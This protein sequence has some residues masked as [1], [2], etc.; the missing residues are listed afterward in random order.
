MKIRSACGDTLP[1]SARSGGRVVWKGMVVCP[2]ACPWEYSTLPRFPMGVYDAAGRDRWLGACRP[3]GFLHARR[4]VSPGSLSTCSVSPCS[5]WVP[6]CF[7][8]GASGAGT[9]MH[10]AGRPCSLLCWVS[11]RSH[12]SLMKA[13]KV[14]ATASGAE[15]TRVMIQ[16][17]LS[18]WGRGRSIFPISLGKS[19]KS[20]DS[21]LVASSITP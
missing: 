20:S 2:V 12:W 4:D 17:S 15:L 14:S 7:A 8:V 1:R 16:R 18:R 6:S 5:I 13:M 9:G 10:L 3:A 11:T 19:S 21:C